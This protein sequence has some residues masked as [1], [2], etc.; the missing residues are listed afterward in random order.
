MISVLSTARLRQSNRERMERLE[1]LCEEDREN[2]EAPEDDWLARTE[3][4]S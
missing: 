1:G 4:V 3:Q 2:S